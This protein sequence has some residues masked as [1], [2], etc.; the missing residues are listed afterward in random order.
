L[1]A[2]ADPSELVYWII[3]DVAS[4]I[5]RSRE[6]SAGRYRPMWVVDWPALMH[7]LSPQWGQRTQARM[8][9]MTQDEW[10]RRR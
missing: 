10:H 9:A 4:A 5:A 3:S 8:D 2:T 1:R 6:S 7:A